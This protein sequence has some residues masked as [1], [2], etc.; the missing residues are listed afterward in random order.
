MASVSLS[1]TVD[2]ATVMRPNDI[3]VGASAPGAGDFELRVDMSKF[4]SMEQIF[5]ALEKLDYFVNDSALGPA[6]FG[7]L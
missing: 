7:S 2:Q 3:V 6:A 5:L 4:T 1:L